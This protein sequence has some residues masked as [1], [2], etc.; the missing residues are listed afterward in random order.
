MKVLLTGS[1]GFIG[2]NLLSKLLEYGIT[3]AVLVRDLSK[4]INPNVV[5]FLGCDSF[6]AIDKA[7]TEFKP[8]LVIHL[9][10][11]YLNS[12][13]PEN[14]PNLI[15]SNITYGTNLLE[16]M[17]KNAIT[18]IVNFGT[19]WQ[20]MNNKDYCPANLYAATKEAFQDI[21][22]Y[23]SKNGIKYKTLELC[24]T[25]GSGDNRKKIVDLLFNACINNTVIDLSPGE[26]IIDLL[27]VKE[28]I[29][30]IA[31]NISSDDFFDN[32]RIQ[33]SGT[34]IKLR[35]LGALVESITGKKGFLNFGGKRYREN[36]V[37]FPPKSD[38]VIVLHRE[39]LI[40]YL[41]EYYNEF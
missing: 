32:R 16:S 40:I 9:A 13:T 29:V 21:L 33:L 15:E 34:E 8:D 28:L 30:F 27:Y 23:Y 19:R 35:D 14:I 26:Q 17:K 39:E 4:E 31:D 3:V 25:F 7:I 38:K 2:K 36:E 24:D 6:D 37:M 22:E 1:T 18:K 20:H 10:T 12:H 41:K 11:L 5:V